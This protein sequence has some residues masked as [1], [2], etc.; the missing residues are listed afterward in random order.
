MIFNVNLLPGIITLPLPAEKAV[1]HAT[2]CFQDALAKLTA[3]SLLL[4]F[5]TIIEGLWG[6]RAKF[7]PL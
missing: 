2:I 6:V 5:V 7:E 3:V 4:Y 1:T